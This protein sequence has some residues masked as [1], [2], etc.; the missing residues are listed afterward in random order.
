MSFHDAVLPAETTYRRLKLD[1]AYGD[2]ETQIAVIVNCRSRTADAEARFYR[3]EWMSVL[4]KT[5]IVA[6]GL[7]ALVV[8]VLKTRAADALSR[9]AISVLCRKISCVVTS[10]DLVGC[11]RRFGETFRPCRQNGSEFMLKIEALRSSETFLRSP[12]FLKDPVRSSANLSPI[13]GQ[14]LRDLPQPLHVIACTVDETPVRFEDVVKDQK[15]IGPSPLSDTIELCGAQFNVTPQGTNRKTS[16]GS[17]DARCNPSRSV[18]SLAIKVQN[19]NVERRYRRVRVLL[20]PRTSDCQ[21]RLYSVRTAKK[22]Q[23]LSITKFNWSRLKIFKNPVRTAKK[24]QHLSITKFNWSRLKIFKNPVRTAK[25]TQHLSIT[26]FNWSRLKIFKNPV[27]TA[28]KTQHLSITKFNWS[29]LKIFKNPVRTAKK[30]QHL[31]ITKFNWSRLKIFKNPVR[32]AKKTQHLSITKFNWSRLKIF[33]NPVRT[34]KK[35]QHLSITK[36]NWSRLKIFKNPVRTAK[37]TQHLSIT[38]FNWSR[39]KIFKNPV[40]TAKKTQH[41]SITKFKW[42]TLFKEV[43][44]VCSENHEEILIVETGVGVGAPLFRVPAADASAFSRLYYRQG[45]ETKELARPVTYNG[46]MMTAMMTNLGR[47]NIWPWKRGGRNEAQFTARVF[48]SRLSKCSSLSLCL[49]LSQLREATF[50][51]SRCSEYSRSRTSKKLAPNSDAKLWSGKQVLPT[52][53]QMPSQVVLTLNYLDH[54]TSRAVYEP[55]EMRQSVGRARSYVGHIQQQI[56]YVRLYAVKARCR[57]RV[58]LPVTLP[59]PCLDSDVRRQCRLIK[60][61]LRF[62]E[63]EARFAPANVSVSRQGAVPRTF[64][65]LRSRTRMDTLC[66]R[67]GSS[68]HHHI[69]REAV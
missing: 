67:R 64:E 35:T 69:K 1:D 47:A 41:L 12:Q 19:E 61:R 9:S 43:I 65:V 25:K 5:L 29:R 4:L 62:S 66:L 56:C 32:T 39:L 2:L 46:L 24:T 34:A 26:K 55:T 58:V 59:D 27:R 57:P 63:R 42:L 52:V 53:G 51:C 50:S 18:P 31:S 33:K 7:S 21:A 54:M 36:F 30:T 23:H 17:R 49:S 6:Q 28:K 15:F 3:S 13:L 8:P 10:R 14:S 44:A 48:C 11:Y 37:K 40:R 45:D 38:K 60:P 68:T 22:T 20:R 16:F